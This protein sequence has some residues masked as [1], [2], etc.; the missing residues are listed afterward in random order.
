ME[1]TVVG[2]ANL[3]KSYFLFKTGRINT[4]VK[5]AFYKDLIANLAICGVCSVHETAAPREYPAPLQTLTCAHQSADCTR[6]AKSLLCMTLRL[7]SAAHGQKY[8]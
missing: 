2:I 1:R 5:L 4:N 7:H 3:Q 8:A 6:L